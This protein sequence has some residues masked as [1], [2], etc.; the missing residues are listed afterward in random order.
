[1]EAYDPNFHKSYNE[2]KF[3]TTYSFIHVDPSEP[4]EKFLNDPRVFKDGLKYFGVR[5]R[6]YD[7]TDNIYITV[8]DEGYWQYISKAVYDAFESKIMDHTSKDWFMKK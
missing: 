4:T 1:M 3:L 8:Y 7:G 6:I 2:D 5:E